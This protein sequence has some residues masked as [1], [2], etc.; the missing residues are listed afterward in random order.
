MHFESSS[1]SIF[2]KDTAE[3]CDLEDF[4][5]SLERCKASPSKDS[6][7][8]C[9]KLFGSLRSLRSLRNLQSPPRKSKQVET[10]RPE[11]PVK[12]QVS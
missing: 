5:V 3:D 8:K 4:G 1:P 9:K 12:R 11:S 2:P 10:P 7:S 6:P